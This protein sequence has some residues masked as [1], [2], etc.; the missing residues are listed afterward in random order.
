MVFDGA[1]HVSLLQDDE[2]FARSLT[3]SSFGKS[4]HATGWKIGYCAGPAGLMQQFRAVHQF[5]QFCVVT[6][7]QAALAEFMVNHPGHTDE[8]AMFYQRKRDLFGELLSDSRFGINPS[9][10]TYF[11]LADYSA[12]SDA[13]DTE[14]TRWLTTEK[15][16]AAIPISVFYANPPEQ[17]VIRFCFAKNDDTLREAAKLLCRI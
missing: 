3:V 4:Y 1:R 10:G 7:L 2:L 13:P 11:Q 16:V 12:I 5:N 14:F 9:A 8:L 15:G 6:P 17:R